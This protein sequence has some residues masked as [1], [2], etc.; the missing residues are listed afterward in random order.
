M[1]VLGLSGK[2]R[3]GKDTCAGIITQIA[4]EE[5][6]AHF[7]QFALAWP[8]KSRVYAEA[9][10]KYSWDDVFVKKVPELRK[11]LQE[12]G[13]ERGRNVFGL[14]FWTMQAESFLRCFETG[15]PFMSAVVISDVRFPNEVD[16]CRYAGRPGNVVEQ[17]IREVCYAELGYT[18]EVEA[19]LLERDPAKLVEMDERWFALFHEKIKAYTESRPGI[20]LY[21]QSNRPTLEGDAAK[22]PSETALDDLDKPTAFDGIIVN[23]VDTTL[24]DLREQLHPYVRDLL[25]L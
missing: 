16:F 24:E 25:T 2:A 6:K 8:L 19:D 7:G 18:A 9:A 17:E 3:H 14:E 22:H 10:G 1:R 15:M 13:T 11:L 23:N 20:S 21:I 4:T 5:Y 12:V